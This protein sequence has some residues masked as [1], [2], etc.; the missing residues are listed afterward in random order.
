M[1]YKK[2]GGSAKKNVKVATRF[3]KYILIIL[4]IFYALR[5][6]IS[7]S[8]QESLSFFDII[9]GYVGAQIDLLNRLVRQNN[10]S[11]SLFG[12][13]S[14]HDLYSFFEKIGIMRNL[15]TLTFKYRAYNGLGCNV[16][17]FFRR[18]YV[19]FG[20]VGSWFISLLTAL[21]PLMARELVCAAYGETDAHLSRDKGEKLWD[22]L[23]TW[24]DR[25]V[26]G[27]FVPTL[28]RRAGRPADFICA[29]QRAGSLYGGRK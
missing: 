2:N 25:I 29:G 9:S 16:Y 22:S 11:Y 12:Y 26:V 23:G 14:F 8:G 27:G 19:D 17:T 15:P 5:L 6:T 3:V 7:K 20:L 28:L 13:E 1:N 21:P 10:I 18:P 4:V 24:R